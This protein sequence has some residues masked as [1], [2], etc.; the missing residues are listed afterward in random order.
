[1]QGDIKLTLS[2]L[3]GVIIYW[4]VMLIVIVTALNAL[5]LTV[6]AELLSRLVAYVPNIII[7]IFVLVLGSFLAN[8]VGTIVRTTASNAGIKKAKSLGQVAQTVLVIFAVIIAV[9]QLNI[10]TTLIAFA[11]NVVLAA[12]GLAIGLAFGLGCKDIAGK[13]LSDIVNDLKK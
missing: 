8:F 3:L 7:A 12:V 4:L 11:V 2:E 6:A 9:E 1:A 13:F 5:N 10:A